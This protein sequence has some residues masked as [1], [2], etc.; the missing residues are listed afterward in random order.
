MAISSVPGSMQSEPSQALR[1]EYEA[2]VKLFDWVDIPPFSFKSDQVVYASL[3]KIYKEQYHEEADLRRSTDS[4]VKDVR[5]ERTTLRSEIDA[6]KNKPQS[7][8][9][10]HIKLSETQVSQASITQLKSQVQE[11]QS[12]ITSAQRKAEYLQSQVEKRDSRVK[13]LES[14]SSSSRAELANLQPLAQIGLEV[15]LRC[16]EKPRLKL[17]GCAKQQL[18]QDVI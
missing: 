4:Y 8:S 11:L 14:S 13:Y 15:R 18:A 12:Q 5:T 1:T 17:E 10:I 16:L 3:F 2:A 6:L 7:D 9:S